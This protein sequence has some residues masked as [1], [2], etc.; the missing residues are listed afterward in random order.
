MAFRNIRCFI[1]CEENC[2]CLVR[3]VGTEFKVADLNV[4]LPSSTDYSLKDLLAS[5]VKVQPVDPTVIHD[6]SATSV[7]ADA[8]VNQSV[9]QPVDQ[10]VDQHVDQ[11]VDNTDA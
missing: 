5:G 4:S 1:P 8:F 2:S 6:S 11:F 9:D 3:L 7:V 10:P